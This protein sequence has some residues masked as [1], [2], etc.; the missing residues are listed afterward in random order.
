MSLPLL[1]PVDEEPFHACAADQMSYEELT[2]LAEQLPATYTANDCWRLGDIRLRLLAAKPT[3]TGLPVM[4]T[5]KNR[6]P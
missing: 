5:D 1:S 2:Q 3:K 4:A 6:S